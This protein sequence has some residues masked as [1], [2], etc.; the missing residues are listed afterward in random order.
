VLGFIVLDGY[1][2]HRTGFR[3]QGGSQISTYATRRFFR[4]WPVYLLATLV[5]VAL[6]FAAHFENPETASSLSGTTQISARCVL[7]KLS[8]T[9]VFR[10]SLHICRF[11]GNAR[12]TTAMVEEWLYILYAV[13]FHA[14]LV[15]GGEKPFW[16]A[17]LIAWLAGLVYT[18]THAEHLAWWHNGSLIRFLPYWWMGA[19]FLGDR[20]RTLWRA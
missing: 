1:R 12:L 13:V 9:S 20:V 2:I 5:G 19:A 7:A 15:G 18:S 6:F 14:V 10:P 4:I 16:L 11:Q 3:R 17:V 8:G